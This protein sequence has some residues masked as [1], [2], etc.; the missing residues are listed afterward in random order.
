MGIR[1]RE[2]LPF[3]NLCITY[4]TN[5][6]KLP[7]YIKGCVVNKFICY[8]WSC[9][10]LPLHPSRGNPVSNS[11][12]TTLKPYTLKG[13]P[14]SSPLDETPS[15]RSRDVSVIGAPVHGYICSEWYTV[16]DKIYDMYT[17]LIKR[18]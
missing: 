18:V 10:L 2:E 9:L 12:T 11:R 1:H 13:A 6:T 14:F 7:G 4:K 8:H 17:V 3:C 5:L 16:R 15:N